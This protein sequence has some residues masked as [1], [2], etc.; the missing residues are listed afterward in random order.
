MKTDETTFILASLKEVNEQLDVL[1]TRF[2]RLERAKDEVLRDVKKLRQSIEL[3]H[4][5]IRSK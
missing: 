4:G 3:L 5:S 2:N 1:N